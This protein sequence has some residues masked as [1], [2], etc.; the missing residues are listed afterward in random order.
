MRSWLYACDTCVRMR[1]TVIGGRRAGP[2]IF[3]QLV[4]AYGYHL[5]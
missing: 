2:L 3:I 5:A 4:V 1:G